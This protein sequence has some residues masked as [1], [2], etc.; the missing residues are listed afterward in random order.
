MNI[1]ETL[2]EDAITEKTKAIAVVHYAGVSWA[3]DEI[4][5]IARRHKLKVVEDAAQGVCACYKGKALAPSEIMD[6]IVSMR[7]RIFPWERAAPCCS[8]MILCWKKLKLS[9]KKGT[10]RSLKFPGIGQIYLGGLWFLLSAK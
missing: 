6:A 9:G 2:I 7:Q 10:N 8:R 1:D 5:D 3:M 4:M